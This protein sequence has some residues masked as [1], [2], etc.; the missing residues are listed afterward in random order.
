MVKELAIMNKQRQQAFKRRKAFALI[1]LLSLLAFVILINA[2][3]VIAD[4][5]MR[6]ITR[7]ED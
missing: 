2:A 4:D 5:C 6:D 7:A 1:R 3:S